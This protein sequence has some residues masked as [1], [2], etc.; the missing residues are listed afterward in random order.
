[1][2]ARIVGVVTVVSILLWAA[3]GQANTLVWTNPASANLSAASSWYRGL[4]PS[5]GGTDNAEFQ[6]LGTN[7]AVTITVDSAWGGAAG[8]LNSLKFQSGDNDMTSNG[9]YTVVAGGGVSGLNI[10]SGGL[11]SVNNSSAQNLSLPITFTA[12]S[13]VSG[14]GSLSMLNLLNASVPCTLTLNNS[15]TFT[16]GGTS[17]AIGA[18][19]TNIV[20]N[21]GTLQT[22]NGIA[23]GWNTN[24]YP[25]TAS[26]TMNGGTLYLSCMVSNSP[27]NTYTQALGR[28]IAGGG[29]C[30][31][32]VGLAQVDGTRAGTTYYKFAGF[33]AP[34]NPATVLILGTSLGVQPQFSNVSGFTTHNGI[35]G[36]WALFSSSF[37]QMPTAN[38]NLTSVTGT[39]RTNSADWMNSGATEN[40]LL[41]TNT[42][43][44]SGN[45]TNNSLKAASAA[46]TSTYLDLGGY[47]LRLDT[48]GLISS[49]SGS[50]TSSTISNGFLTVGATD[51]SGGTLYVSGNR[52]TTFG[53]NC[54]IRDNGTGSVNVVYF[55]NQSPTITSTNT[56]SGFTAI[57]AIQGV[58]LALSI[59][60]DGVSVGDCSILGKVPASFVANNVQLLGGILQIPAGYTVNLHPNRGVYLGSHG[61][62]I[63]NSGTGILNYNGVISG[64]GSLT[65]GI[66]A[67]LGGANPNTYSGPTYNTVATLTLQKN[68]NVV[69]IP[70]DL[71]IT[72]SGGSSADRLVQL[73]ANEQ[74]ADMAV[75]T[76]LRP[77]NGATGSSRCKFNLNGFNE[78]IGGLVGTS[79]GG[80]TPAL[81]LIVQN[82]SSSANSQLSIN[83]V[84]GSFYRYS[85]AV[86]NGGS[87]P[88]SL[89]IS[90]FG[91]QALS[92]TNNTYSGGT[93]VN[94]GTLIVDNPAV[95]GVYGAGTGPTIVTNTGALL[96][97]GGSLASNVT[98]AAG[99]TLQGYGTVAGSLT[100]NGTLQLNAAT[101]QAAALSVGSN[102]VL[103]GTCIVT[104]RGTNDF[105]SIS[106]GGNVTLG[107]TLTIQPVGNFKIP[108]DGT[109]LPIL[110]V[111]GAVTGV[112]GQFT[113]ITAGYVVTTSGKQVLLSRR[114]PGFMFS[115][116]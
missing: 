64:P 63:G 39:S 99:A 114:L 62:Q 50:G 94:G 101:N 80:S 23:A 25:D 35:V 70:G 67:S 10:G 36:G 96:L 91:A 20:L 84:A 42:Y 60:N 34:T 116:R 53:P 81:P 79:Y 108:T 66:G 58:S 44:L 56:Y 68:N 37:L 41:T 90:G 98:V 3:S 102:L 61:G 18:N 93:T 75:V 69:A 76:L 74:I 19:V 7:T 49:P 30:E 54:V 92:G 47:E 105:D 82:N 9:V 89:V 21:A 110:T 107:G 97:L 111:T 13:Q 11:I 33:T 12:N 28:L 16:L 52:S 87:K 106:A 24:R 1:M 113:G 17:G 27:G 103:N 88:L 51:N 72:A 86:Q 112:S 48:G 73:G 14:S 46:S 77:D 78:T 40:V 6:Q 59:T 71:I 43:S 4:A 100:V 5:S 2:Q 115:A 55:A 38:A 83:T 31:V 15:G 26:I 8:S 57:A 65:F 45:L 95:A 29:V 85:G 109:K 32:K 104:V 22:L